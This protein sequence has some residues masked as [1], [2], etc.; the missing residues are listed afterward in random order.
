MQTE[1]RPRK[2]DNDTAQRTSRP[3]SPS[4][5]V[6][7]HEAGQGQGFG[8]DSQA[9]GGQPWG[10]GPSASFAFQAQGPPYGQAAFPQQPYGPGPQ[11]Q[12]QAAF[13]NPFA[14]FAPTLS[15]GL[16]GVADLLYRGATLA[17]AQGQALL[18]A[19]QPPMAGRQQQPQVAWPNARL[20]PV[21]IVDEGAELVCQVEL[22]G[23]KPESV[24]VACHGRGI[25]VTA[26]AEPDI[27]L[28]SLVQAERGLQVTYRRAI[29]LPAVVNPS[30]AKARLRDG[31]LTIN[32][33]KADPTEGPRRVPVE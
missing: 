23:T 3:R 16:A 28:G 5:N 17:T 33:P 6:R 30:G 9:W 21:D 31:I 7:M 26:H 20:P 25:L 29:Q 13:P 15:Y 19:L 11:A 12:P 18:G 4:S 8:F 24:D 1:T 27:D 32:V 2:D 14:A 22:P 10:G